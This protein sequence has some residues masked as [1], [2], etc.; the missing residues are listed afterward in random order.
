[1]RSLFIRKIIKE[2]VYAPM[3]VYI[4][5]NYFHDLI[6]S[7]WKKPHFQATLRF[8]FVSELDVKKPSN[9]NCGRLRK[10]DSSLCSYTICNYTCYSR[11]IPFNHISCFLESITLVVFKTLRIKLLLTLNLFEVSI[12]KAIT[13]CYPKCIVVI[14]PC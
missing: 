12:F 9:A 11:F 10:L 4:P 8:P 13:S 14:G 6:C 7:Q 3:L 1:M 5:Q 2:I